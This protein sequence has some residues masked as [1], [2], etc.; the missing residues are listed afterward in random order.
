MATVTCPAPELKTVSTPTK[1]LIN[2][3]WVDSESGK[4]FRDIQPGDRRGDRAG[5]GSRR[6]RRRQGRVGGTECVRARSLANDIR[7]RTRAT[8]ESA[9]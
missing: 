4:T 7:R 9:G 6:R 3:Q 2:N 8:D 1:L 5:S